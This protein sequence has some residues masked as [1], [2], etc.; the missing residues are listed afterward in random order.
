MN[1]NQDDTEP[2]RGKFKDYLQYSAIG[3]EMGLSVVVGVLIGS[4][5]D[6]K[7]D[8]APW[9]LFFWLLCGFAA[10]M[11]S[12]FKLVKIQ[13]QKSKESEDEPE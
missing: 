11:R 12:I 2:K 4:W 5:L 7:F 13:L 3:I 10:G 1:S 8:T 9:F 6:E